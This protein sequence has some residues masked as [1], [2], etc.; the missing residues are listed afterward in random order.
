MEVQNDKLDRLIYKIY[1]EKKSYA[2]WQRERY[3]N[4]Y[5]VERH[6]EKDHGHSEEERKA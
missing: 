1:K 2:E 6:K 4:L 5:R 3:A